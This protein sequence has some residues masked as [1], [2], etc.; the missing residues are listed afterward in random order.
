MRFSLGS[1]GNVCTVRCRNAAL[2]G[3]FGGCFAVQ[4]TDTAGRND[5]SPAGVA[6][7]QSLDAVL[8]Q[9]A[10][11]QADL[12]AAIA[13]NQAAGAAGLNPGAAAAAGKLCFKRITSLPRNVVRTSEADYLPIL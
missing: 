9:V 12:P 8:S 7:A 10:V 2:A 3:P 13:A 5:S 1:T 6:T 4:Q 11:D